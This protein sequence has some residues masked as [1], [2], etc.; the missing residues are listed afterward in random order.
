MFP[1][2][3]IGAA[4]PV[5]KG[6][7]AG[8]PMI[9]MVDADD[10]AEYRI[11]AR[12]AV[13][14]GT[15]HQQNALFYRVARGVDDASVLKRLPPAQAFAVVTQQI[16]AGFIVDLAQGIGPAEIVLRNHPD[17]GFDVLGPVE[18]V[19]VQKAYEVGIDDEGAAGIDLV[20]V[21]TPSAD[22]LF[23]GDGGDFF[24][25]GAGVDDLPDGG[26]MLGAVEKNIVGDVGVGLL[27]D[28][29]DAGPQMFVADARRDH[30]YLHLKVPWRRQI[31]GHG[32][33]LLASIRPTIFPGPASRGT[34]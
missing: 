34:A 1:G 15:H 22:A 32:A 17:Q 29:F 16:G 21:K 24:V 13:P 26:E 7:E 8:A 10:F 19:L 3:G 25:P 12:Y 4:Q 6:V 23:Q 9:W 31:R 33:G 20:A 5:A 14:D 2:H 18:I 28:A 27:L 30:R 11:G